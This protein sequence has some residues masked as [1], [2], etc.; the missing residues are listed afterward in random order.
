MPIQISA[1]GAINGLAPCNAGFSVAAKSLKALSQEA[2]LH[3]ELVLSFRPPPARCQR[4]LYDFK[5]AKV[6]CVRGIWII[7]RK[8]MLSC[9]EL[10]A[11]VCNHVKS[12]GT[13]ITGGYTYGRSSSAGFWASWCPGSSADAACFTDCLSGKAVDKGHFEMCNILM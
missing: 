11:S 1:A 9:P 8:V 13:I 6:A 12:H 10:I 3:S 5:I 2:I 4:F 7:D